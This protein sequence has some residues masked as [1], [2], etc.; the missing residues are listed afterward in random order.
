MSRKMNSILNMKNIYI[1]EGVV[2]KEERIGNSVLNTRI[3]LSIICCSMR[4]SCIKKME[5]HFEWNM[6]VDG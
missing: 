2:G 1:W 4:I 6:S 3:S 5:M